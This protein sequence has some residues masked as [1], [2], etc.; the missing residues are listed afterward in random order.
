MLAAARRG[1]ERPGRAGGPRFDVVIGLNYYWPYV[2]GLSEV[3]RVVA[4]HLVAS[5]LRV[6]VVTSRFDPSLPDFE[7]HEGVE[8]ER[9][10][11]LFGVRN[12]VVSPQL[13]V[14]L[15]RRIRQSR[16]G[17]L[18]L[19]M[20]EAGPVAAFVGDVPLLTTYHCDYQTSGRVVGAAIAAVVDA[21]SRL[22]LRRSDVVVASSDDYASHSRVHGS[23]RDKT[24]A[25]PPPYPA[26]AGGRPRF[27]RSDGLHVGTLGRV[28]EEKGLDVLIDA[29]RTIDDDD[30]R[31]LIAGSYD[32]VAGASLIDDLRARAGGDSRIAFLGFLADDDVADYLASLDVFAFPSVNSLEAFGIT[33]LEAISAG[34]PVVASDLPGVRL[35]VLQT[36]QGVLVPAR[37]V[38]RLAA[39]LADPAT[40]AMRG[41]ASRI[42]GPD[43][44]AHQY[45]TLVRS[46]LAGPVS[47]G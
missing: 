30:A 13:P 41:D 25:I 15:V 42:G 46:L 7:I 3:A 40:R 38:G 9:T 32:E 19:P 8:I 31:L 2:S 39:A 21:S 12:G 1:A 36:G 47:R 17:H 20:L 33:Q 18:H 45:E 37:D 28:V 4:E 44:S 16:L 10:R 35:P 11:V 14:R 27:R 43:A 24:V 26:R 22:A 29:F 34:L 6:R 5:G 23:M